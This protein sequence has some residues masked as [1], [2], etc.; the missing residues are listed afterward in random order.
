MDPSWVRGMMTGRIP[1]SPSFARQ[2]ERD[3]GIP[4]AEWP[5]SEPAGLKSDRLSTVA[6]PESIRRSMQTTKDDGADSSRPGRKISPGSPMGIA[7]RNSGMT[8]EAIAKKL[9]VPY[10]TVKSWGTKSTPKVDAQTKL[11]AKPFLVPLVAW[12]VAKKRQQA[13][14]RKLDAAR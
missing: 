7:A 14:A 2:V 12:K 8:I 3:L 5:L 9:H 13:R 10:S 1:V 6:Y 11:A 4:A